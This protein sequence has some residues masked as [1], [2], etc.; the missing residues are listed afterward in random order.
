MENNYL[1]QLFIFNLIG[2]KGNEVF[3]EY[4]G[5]ESESGDDDD[6]ECNG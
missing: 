1:D 4:R 5:T 6:F 3:N 2:S